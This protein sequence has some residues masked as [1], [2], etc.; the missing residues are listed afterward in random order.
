VGF[1]LP[2]ETLTDVEMI[3]VQADIASVTLHHF[4]QRAVA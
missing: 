4:T 2:S 3:G 1:Q